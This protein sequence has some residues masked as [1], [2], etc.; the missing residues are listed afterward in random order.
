MNIIRIGENYVNLD[1]AI[2]IIPHDEEVLIVTEQRNYR[3]SAYS[4]DVM[5]LRDLLEKMSDKTKK[6]WEG[7]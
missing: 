2:S 4:S 5:E 7:K 3:I 6:D 1:N